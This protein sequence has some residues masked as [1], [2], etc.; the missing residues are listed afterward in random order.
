MFF[1]YKETNHVCGYRSVVG[2]LPSK[3]TTPVRIRLPAP[4]M[5]LLIFS[6]IY[7]IIYIEKLRKNK[8][9]GSGKSLTNHIRL[10]TTNKVYKLCNIKIMRKR[11]YF[12]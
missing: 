10:A 8:K 12:T 11:E 5:I 1:T 3:Q 4:I 9:F 2:P 6:K 7:N